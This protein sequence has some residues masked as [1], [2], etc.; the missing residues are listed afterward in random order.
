MGYRSSKYTFGHTHTTLE[1][2]VTHLFETLLY[3]LTTHKHKCIS[4]NKIFIILYEGTKILFHFIYFKMMCYICE[5]RPWIII[6]SK[7]GHDDTGGIFGLIVLQFEFLCK[8]IK[9][10]VIKYMTYDCHQFNL[11]ILILIQKR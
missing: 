10:Y 3:I 6:D 8:F 2:H 9:F 7:S 4:T 1:I 5:F 11:T